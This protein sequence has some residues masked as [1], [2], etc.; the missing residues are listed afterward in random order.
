MNV[1]EEVGKLKE[2]IQRLG[3]KQP[4]GSYKVPPWPLVSLTLPLRDR[5]RS[6]PSAPP[7]FSSSVLPS[8]AWP[9]LG[10]LP[11]SLDA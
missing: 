1:E 8:P 2:E 4:D 9:W 10:F 6:E 3:Q 11:S 5:R 7:H